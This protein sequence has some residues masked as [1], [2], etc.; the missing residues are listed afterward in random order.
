M[1]L[2]QKLYTAV[3]MCCRV[4]A[5]A[6]LGSFFDVLRLDARF[7]SLVCLRRS[8][9]IHNIVKLSDI[10]AHPLLVACRVHFRCLKDGVWPT[11]HSMT[12][13]R[14]PKSFRFR[15]SPVHQTY[16][17]D[18]ALGDLRLLCGSASQCTQCTPCL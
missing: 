5:W 16:P 2:P 9:N 3:L 14:I 8:S 4:S 6:L 11:S 12:P 13:L 1:F 7:L 15:Q 10:L 17:R 18:C